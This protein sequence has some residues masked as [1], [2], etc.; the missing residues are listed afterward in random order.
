[1][2]NGKARALACAASFWRVRPR[3]ESDAPREDDL[4]SLTLI[5]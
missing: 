2:C 3:T 1:M 5:R 4:N